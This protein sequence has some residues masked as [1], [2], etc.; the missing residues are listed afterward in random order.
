[1]G[2]LTGGYN[3]PL[4]A[5]PNQYIF[6]DPVHPTKHVHALLAQDFMNAMPQLNRNTML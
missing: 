3:Y 5:N 4:C 2:S 6:W 1:M